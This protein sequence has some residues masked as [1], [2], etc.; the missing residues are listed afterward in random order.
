MST[1][2][3]SELQNLFSGS[4]GHMAAMGVVETYDLG[5]L[6]YTARRHTLRR[7]AM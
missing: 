3:W 5:T 6:K 4:P 1:R 7:S 2:P